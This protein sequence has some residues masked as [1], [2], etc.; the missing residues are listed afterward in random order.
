MDQLTQQVQQ[1]LAREGLSPGPIDG[2]PGRKTAAALRAYQA[3]HKLT[4]TGQAD[5]ATLSLL[6]IGLNPEEA[7][8]PPWVTLAR[9]K[10]GLREKA[11]NKTLSDWLK[12]GGGFL[13]DPAELPWC[14]DFI[15]TDYA[16]TL[17]NE[18]LPSNPYYA[19]N[20]ASFGVAVAKG[21][22]P[23]G[24][25]AVFTRDG[26]GHVA[27]VVG[28]DKTHFHC[29]GGN[30]SN[31]VSIVRIAKSRLLGPLRWPKTY[32]PPTRTLPIT[33]IDATVSTNEA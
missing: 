28:H 16:L 22:I 31:A 3:M 24:A 1:A 21:M 33:T 32:A 30:Q 15:E 7:E 27:L 18:P 13:G 9:H 14:G 23:L 26:G 20:W 5:L 8:S 19:R 29:L 2:L 25:L 6:G 10:M 17:P 11:D 4:V 12:S